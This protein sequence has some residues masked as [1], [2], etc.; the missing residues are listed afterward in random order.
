MIQ[1]Q[2]EGSIATITWD[3]PQR[4]TNVLNQVAMIAFDQAV[5]RAL[6]DDAVNG[7]IIKSAKTDFIAGADLQM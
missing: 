5:D 4:T 6:A 1:Y 7:V 3:M 2:S